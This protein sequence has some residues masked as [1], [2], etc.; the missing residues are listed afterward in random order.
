M[1]SLHVGTGATFAMCIT[2]MI[3]E[4]AVTSGLGS[5]LK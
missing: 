1:K 4:L 5:S 2:I 3:T